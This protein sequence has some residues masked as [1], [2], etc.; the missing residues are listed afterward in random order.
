MGSIQLGVQHAIG[1][2]ASKPDRDI[3]MPVSVQ[4]QHDTDY[5]DSDPVLRKS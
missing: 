5:S 1:G 4:L 3:L 2:L